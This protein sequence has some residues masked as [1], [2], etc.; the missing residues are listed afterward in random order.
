M[1]GVEAILLPTLIPAGASIVAVA[2][3]MLIPARG[4][5]LLDDT[6]VLLDKFVDLYNECKPKM[7]QIQ[8]E[9]ATKLWQ[10]C[11][12]LWLVFVFDRCSPLCPRAD[13]RRK[14]VDSLPKGL[15]AR[16]SENIFGA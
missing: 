12:F 14:H 2:I 11:V 13:A 15:R 8:M 3:P 1:S 9:N 10:Q 6:D 7:T 16:M 4:Q 5:E